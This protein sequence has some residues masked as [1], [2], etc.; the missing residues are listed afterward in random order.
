M[1]MPSFAGTAARARRRAHPEQPADVGNAASVRQWAACRRH[2]TTAAMSMPAE[3]LRAPMV[4]AWTRRAGIS[5]HS[6]SA[7]ELDL[8]LTSGITPA[9]ITLH[10]NN[11]HTLVRR[12]LHAGIGRFV[13][14]TPA[15]SDALTFY[16]PGVHRV[17]IDSTAAPHLMDQVAS[18]DRL[19]I[20]GVHHRLAQPCAPLSGDTLSTAAVTSTLADLCQLRR[21]TGHIATRLSFAGAIPAHTAAPRKL[22][23]IAQELESTV[24][25]ACARFRYPRPALIIQC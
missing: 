10:C 4:A 1:N 9:R 18:S 19:E 8:A 20:L 2:L 25:D 23:A 14:A 3:Q 24:E 15:H 7:E 16:T 13:I 17:L 5:V 22:R 12:A 11:D 21:H 6:H